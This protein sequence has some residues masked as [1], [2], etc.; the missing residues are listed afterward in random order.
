VY[1]PEQ[2]LI[3]GVLKNTLL[4]VNGG[5]EALQNVGF[6][7]TILQQV[8]LYAKVT[9]LKK[10]Q[11]SNTKFPFKTVYFFGV[12]GLTTSSCVVYDH[13]TSGCIDL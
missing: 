13:A 11:K 5:S 12:W 4:L 8:L 2:W 3:V 7:Y 10:S 1:Q 9:F 6:F